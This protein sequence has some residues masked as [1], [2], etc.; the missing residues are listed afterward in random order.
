MYSIDSFPAGFHTANCLIFA[1][2]KILMVC[3]GNICRSPLAEGLCK[4]LLAERLGC[5]LEEL[6]QRGF[7]VLS[8]GLSALRSWLAARNPLAGCGAM[9]WTGWSTAS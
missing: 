1:A 5:S 3:L 9:A 2:M 6:P 8:A 4:K 7:V